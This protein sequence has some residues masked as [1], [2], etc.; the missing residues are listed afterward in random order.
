MLGSILLSPAHV[1]MSSA[2]DDSS[3]VSSKGP[4]FMR[5]FSFGIAC[6][7]NSSQEA[8]ED[9]GWV[10]LNAGEEC[11]IMSKRVL[12]LTG[13]A[14]LGACSEEKTIL[15][16]VDGPAPPVA[17]DVVYYNRAVTVYWELSSGWNGE[18]F[19]VFGQTGRRP[20]FRAHRRRDELLR[21]KL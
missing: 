12:L 14:L 16:P 3:R 10:P 6:A 20:V 2:E 13:L 18:T 17:L 7:L 9:S 11:E 19:R 4:D 5:L 15:V 1:D 8:V 21:R